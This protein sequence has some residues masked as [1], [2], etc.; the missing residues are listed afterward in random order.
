MHHSRGRTDNAV[1]WMTPARRFY[2]RHGAV[3]VAHTVHESADGAPHPA[4][5]HAWPDASVL[6]RA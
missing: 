4:R 1:A 2:E 3:V 6:S 5:C